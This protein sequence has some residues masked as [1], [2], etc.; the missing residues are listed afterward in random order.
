VDLTSELPETELRRTYERVRSLPLEGQMEDCIEQ[1]SHPEVLVSELLDAFRELGRCFEAVEIGGPPRGV[2][3]APGE[4]FYPG[5]DLSVLGASRAFTCLASDVD[6]LAGFRSV[7]SPVRQ[8]FDFV[9]VTCDA[10]TT[11]VLGA[12]QSERDLSAYSLLLRLLAS[13]A[14]MSPEC[15]LERMGR[16]FFRGVLSERTVFDLN[17]VLWDG[18]DSESRTP[19]CQLTRDL[20]EKMKVTLHEQSGIVQILRD[21][22]CVRMNPSRFDGRLR[23]EWYV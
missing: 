4:L 16:E 19:L 3:E 20:A 11:P 12:M 8:G 22:V 23:L 10:T 18:D 6:P 9:G 14:E 13:L 17:I 21:I 7:T 1:L 15:Q 2:M 5:R